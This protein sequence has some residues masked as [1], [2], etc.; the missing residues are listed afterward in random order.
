[1]LYKVIGV[2]IPIF[3]IVNAF[4]MLKTKN[5]KLTILFIF[6]LQNMIVIYPLFDITHSLIVALPLFIT[7]IYSISLLIVES[8]IYKVYEYSRLNI[9]KKFFNVT[10]III[11]ILLILAIIGFAIFNFID[12]AKKCNNDLNHLCGIPIKEDLH[13]YINKL[14]LFINEQENNGKKTYIISIDAVLPMIVA[15]KHNKNYDMLTKGNLGSKGEEGLIEEINN[16]RNSIFLI[17]KT[18]SKNRQSTEMVRSY[19]Q[20]NFKKIRR[21][22][23]LWS[24]Y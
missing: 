8:K 11:A 13:N 10:I 24:I 16:N 2:L 6:S 9:L 7:F 23:R 1:M 3:I 5:L 4:A 12:Y 18:K 17:N 19:I 22:I 15:D 20:T 21:Y 14:L